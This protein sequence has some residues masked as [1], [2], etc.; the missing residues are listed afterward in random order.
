MGMGLPVLNINIFIKGKVF[1]ETTSSK[2]LTFPSSHK[3]SIK[4]LDD[5]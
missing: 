2:I 4:E 3:E 1:S 5:V